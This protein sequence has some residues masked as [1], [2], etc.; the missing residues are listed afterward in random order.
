SG[1]SSKK[2]LRTI[3]SGGTTESCMRSGGVAAGRLERTATTAAARKPS[4]ATAHGNHTRRR[5]GASATTPAVDP[6]PSHCSSRLTSAALCQRSSG[7]LAR[8]VLTTRSSTGGDMGCT[9]EIDGGSVVM[10]EEIN[11]A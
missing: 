8:Q 4:A 6:S 7:S 9:V 10:I 5:E 11:D 3:R 1:E 2:S